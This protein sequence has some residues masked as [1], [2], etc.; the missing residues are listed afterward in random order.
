MKIFYSQHFRGQIL[1]AIKTEISDSIDTAP[2]EVEVEPTQTINEVKIANNFS[3]LNFYLLLQTVYNKKEE[4]FIFSTILE[5]TM[6]DK[7]CCFPCN[8]HNPLI[9]SRLADKS[10]TFEISMGNARNSLEGY[11]PMEPHAD[12]SALDDDS[13]LVVYILL[14]FRDF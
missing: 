12:L 3:E 11:Q 5:A 13:K 2:S 7:R 6:I 8:Y 9:F 1:I 10:I 4:F 14:K